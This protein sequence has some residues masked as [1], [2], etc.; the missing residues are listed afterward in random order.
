MQNRTSIV[1]AHRFSTIIDAD[2]IHVVKNGEIIEKGNHEELMKQNGEYRK[3]FDM[4]YF[5]S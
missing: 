3:I 4:Q 5:V 2:E 1:I